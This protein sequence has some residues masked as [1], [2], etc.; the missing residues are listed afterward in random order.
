MPI[1]ILYKLINFISIYRF[2]DNAAKAIYQNKVSKAYFYYV[3][4]D[5]GFKGWVAG[6]DENNEN[7]FVIS[8]SYRYKKVHFSQILSCS[9]F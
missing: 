4:I 3:E 7:T 6:P 5:N 9:N 1:A 8:M 2:H